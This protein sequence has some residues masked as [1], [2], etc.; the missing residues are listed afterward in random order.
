MADKRVRG[1]FLELLPTNE[2]RAAWETFILDIEGDDEDS[3][4]KKNKEIAALKKEYN[5][6]IEDNDFL[7]KL[8]ELAEVEKKL[9]QQHCYIEPDITIGY[10]KQKRNNETVTYILGRSPFYTPDV[11]R[12]EMRIYLGRLDDFDNKSIDELKKEKP[13]M[14]NAKIQIIKAMKE[15]LI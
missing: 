4:L 5:K 14:E 6:L 3:R 12:R 11:K 1:V 8:H 13:F 9:I 10:L 2:T 7:D 15:E